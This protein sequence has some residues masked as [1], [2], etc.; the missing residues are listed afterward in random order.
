MI[1][2][3]FR[4]EKPQNAADT[5]DIDYEVFKKYFWSAVKHGVM[6]PPSPFEAYF[7]ATVHE[8]HE[9]QLL[10]SFEKLWVLYSGDEYFGIDS[11]WVS[12]WTL[13]YI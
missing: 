9:D 3:H 6:L 10:S 2:A 4:K 1:S 8:Q 5:R 13:S 7:L 12:H 11:D